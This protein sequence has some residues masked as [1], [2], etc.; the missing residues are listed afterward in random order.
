MVLVETILMKLAGHSDDI[1]GISTNFWDRVKKVQV[2]I[3][4]MN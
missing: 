1:V 4:L 2:C 3:L